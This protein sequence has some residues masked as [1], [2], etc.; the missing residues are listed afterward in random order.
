MLLAVFAA[1][2]LPPPS[3]DGVTAEQAIARAQEVYGIASVARGCRPSSGD[4]IVVCADRGTDQ[5]LPQTA[6]DP[7][8]RAG[9]HV[10]DNGVPRAPQVGP[11]SC[12]GQPG[13]IAIGSAP[14]PPYYIDVK[15]LPE[16][17]PGSDADKIAKGEA[18]AR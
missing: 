5:R 6:P 7:N 9:R 1:A 10:L 12:K 8:T 11:G 14:P 3:H 2:A 13:C 15:S 17:P 4:E 16:A 18:P